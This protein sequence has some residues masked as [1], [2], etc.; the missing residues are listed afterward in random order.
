MKKIVCN[1]RMFISW[2]AFYVYNRERLKKDLNELNTKYSITKTDW[3]FTPICYLLLFS[4]GGC[5]ARTE[6]VKLAVVIS[7]IVGL[8]SFILLCRKNSLDRTTE[9]HEKG[10]RKAHVLH[11]EREQEACEVEMEEGPRYIDCLKRTT[12]D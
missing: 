6:G 11:K 10:V 9:K 7:V 5:I 12:G 3:L 4:V 2:H 1:D 8:M